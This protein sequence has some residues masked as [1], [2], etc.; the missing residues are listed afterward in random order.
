M[1]KRLRKWFGFFKAEWKINM[2]GIR[3]IEVKGKR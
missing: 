3:R 2:V 1:E